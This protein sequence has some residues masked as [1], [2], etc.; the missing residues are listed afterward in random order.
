ME[1][2]DILR[3]IY[4]VVGEK[5]KDDEGMHSIANVFYEMGNRE[6]EWLSEKL[7]NGK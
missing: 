7:Q 2:I 6:E 5:K 4:K 1:G 3:Q